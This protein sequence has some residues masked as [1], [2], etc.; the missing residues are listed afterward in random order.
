MITIC[1]SFIP[2]D[3]TL[4]SHPL[5]VETAAFTVWQSKFL[6]MCNDIQT[7]LMSF[8]RDY[9]RELGKDLT[10]TEMKKASYDST[11]KKLTQVPHDRFQSI[12]VTDNFF[13]AETSKFRY[14]ASV[15]WFVASRT[16][17]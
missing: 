2:S 8:L 16:N 15:N 7:N 1:K 13:T 11:Y 6:A 14:Y 5:P 17:E 10:S 12:L 3:C 4:L 9:M